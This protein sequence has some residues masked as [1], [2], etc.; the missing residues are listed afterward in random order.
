MLQSLCMGDLNFCCPNFPI[1]YL[2]LHV[3]CLYNSSVADATF[4][5]HMTRHLFYLQLRRDILEERAMVNEDQAM[6]LAAVALQ[7]EYDD[8]DPSTCTRN[9]F[10]PEHY[11]PPRILRS[12]GSVYV[13]DNLPALHKE[14]QGQD[15][16]EAE[17]RFM[18]VSA[19]Q[20]H[21]DYS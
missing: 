15:Q 18:D 14:Q 6:S 20:F 4:R 13:R 5:H 19:L 21:D 17:H 11:L 1:C 3:T 10:M 7:S 2:N 16:I 9:Y 12:L 8:Y